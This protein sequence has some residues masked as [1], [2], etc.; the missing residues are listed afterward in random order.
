MHCNMTNTGA[1]LVVSVEPKE[2]QGERWFLLGLALGD[3]SMSIW[4]TPAQLSQ[5]SFAVGVAQQEAEQDFPGAGYYPEGGPDGDEGQIR[6]A[7][8]EAL[9]VERLYVCPHG[10]EGEERALCAGCAADQ[11]APV[12]HPERHST[13]AANYYLD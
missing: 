8:R 1:G 13:T 3:S 9:E 7:I 10:C 6:E 12:Y 4:L 5:L 2:L 11:L